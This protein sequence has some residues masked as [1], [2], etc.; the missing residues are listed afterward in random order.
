MNRAPGAGLDFGSLTISNADQIESPWL[1]SETEPEK[2]LRGHYYSGT[3]KPSIRTT[4]PFFDVL[5][6]SDR[7][8]QIIKGCVALTHNMYLTIKRT[9]QL[10]F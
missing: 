3:E 7:H 8:N 9:A 5:H 4:R 6:Y 10:K 1:Y 2:C